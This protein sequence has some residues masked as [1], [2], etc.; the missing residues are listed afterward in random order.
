MYDFIRNVLCWTH[1]VK[2]INSSVSDCHS[3]AQIHTLCNSQRQL[4]MFFLEAS[5]KN[6]GMD[7][8]RPLPR[9]KQ[10]IQFVL[11]IMNRYTKPTKLIR[12]TERSASTTAFFCPEHWVA[13]YRISSKMLTDHGPQFVSRCFVAD[14]ITFNVHSITTAAYHPQS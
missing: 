8:L 5:L 11:V 9:T 4:N 12:T 2:E 13:S 14:C 7:I 3:C 6:I 10:A 1:M